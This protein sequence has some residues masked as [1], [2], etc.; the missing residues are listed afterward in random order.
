VAQKNNKIIGGIGFASLNGANAEVCELR[1]M[2]L[3]KEARGFGLANKLLILAI[4]EAKATYKTMYLETLSHMTQAISLY[5][6]FGFN[7]LSQPMGDTGHYSCDI[8][9]R[10]EIS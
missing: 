8:W 9:M 7:Y 6:K 3:D 4:N 2:Y 1:K 5:C 10:K